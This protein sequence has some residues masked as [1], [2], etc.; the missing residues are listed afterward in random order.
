VRPWSKAR[1]ASL[2]LA[3]GLPCGRAARALNKVRPGLPGD[4]AAVLRGDGSWSARQGLTLV[5]CSAQPE[6]VMTRNVPLNTL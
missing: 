2:L 6:P 4:V 1:A 3:A 5:H